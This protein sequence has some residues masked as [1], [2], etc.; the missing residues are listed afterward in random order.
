MRHL[1]ALAITV[2]VVAGYTVPALAATN[3]KDVRSHWATL[4]IESLDNKSVLEGY[5][6]G[7]F[8]PNRLV[9]REEFN[10][11]VSK[12][13][14]T[15]KFG[16]RPSVSDLWVGYPNREAKPTDYVTRA[17]ALSVLAKAAIADVPSAD[18]IERLLAKFTDGKQVPTWAQPAVVEAIDSSIFRWQKSIRPN[19]QITRGEAAFLV[20]RLLEHNELA[21]R[22]QLEIYH[23]WDPVVENQKVKIMQQQKVV[24]TKPT[25]TTTVATALSSEYSRV[26]DQVKLI[27]NDP[28]VTTDGTV[29]PEGSRIIGTVKEVQVGGRDGQATLSVEF[30]QAVTPDN[31]VIS[32]TGVVG[33]A[34]GYL[35]PDSREVLRQASDSSY[36]GLKAQ[37]NTEVGAVRKE[38]KNDVY[39]VGDTVG[40]HY[41]QQLSAS[42]R[43]NYV[44]VGVG[45]RLEIKLNGAAHFDKKIWR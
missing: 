39:S 4:A 5:E 12:A 45:D 34:D 27:L 44:L 33:T 6:D 9:T 42:N 1:V 36:S 41:D 37:V 18:K 31:R 15:Q 23:A 3:F 40:A 8:R 25:F 32:I 20:D 21:A 10:T 35:H 38:L 29:V 19:Q 14:A 13:I 24:E 26:G 2:G 28:F 11:F 7:N 22:P 16:P 30:T 43:P 17:E